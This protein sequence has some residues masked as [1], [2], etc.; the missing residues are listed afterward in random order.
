M[1]ASG[2]VGTDLAVPAGQGP[3]T[4]PGRLGSGVGGAL[5]GVRGAG[6]AGADVSVPES[7]WPCAGLAPSGGGLLRECARSRSYQPVD[8]AQ[9][10]EGCPPGREGP[11]AGESGPLQILCGA[12]FP[13]RVS[14]TAGDPCGRE[15]AK[16]GAAGY[17]QTDC[18]AA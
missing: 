16:V 8:G 5:A 18:K 15:G 4:P 6:R 10:E 13:R 14:C 7:Q 11:R 3:E 17:P 1:G 9:H 12:G 2:I